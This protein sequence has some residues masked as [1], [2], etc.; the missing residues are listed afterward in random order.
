MAKFKPFHSW[1]ITRWY[2]VQTP[3]FVVGLVETIKLIVTIFLALTALNMTNKLAALGAAGTTVGTVFTFLVV[4]AI[5]GFASLFIFGP[6]VYIGQQEGNR[7]RGMMVLVWTLTWI[8]V[9]I[10]IASLY[11]NS[12]PEPQPL[13]FDLGGGAG[14]SEL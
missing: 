5:F 2:F 14:G 13:Q 6:M 9:V 7:E 10:L 1:G 3:A 8:A 12:L 11:F 4:V